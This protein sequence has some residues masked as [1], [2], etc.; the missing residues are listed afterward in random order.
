MTSTL[1]DLPI[2][3]AAIPGAAW[4]AHAR[5]L[6]RRL[7]GHRHDPVTG[8]LTR[9]GWTARA[10]RLARRHPD[11]TVALVLT[12]PADQAHDRLHELC[13]A[14]EQPVPWPGGPLAVGASIG[15]VPLAGRPLGTALGAA[16]QAMYQVKRGGRRGRAR[17]TAWL[18]GAR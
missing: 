12:S 3:A 7:S 17:V 13:Q 2:L 10:E 5:V 15:S 6:Y 8:L 9:A 16:D 18:A 4:A 1:F 14:L 11:A